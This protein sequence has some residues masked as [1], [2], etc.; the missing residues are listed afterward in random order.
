MASSV[1][2]LTALFVF[3]L[4]AGADVFGERIEIFEEGLQLKVGVRSVSNP[5]LRDCDTDGNCDGFDPDMA[6]DICEVL[7]ADCEFVLL[8]TLEDRLSFLEDDKV[9]FVMDSFS[10]T[11]ERKERI[12]FVNPFYYATGAALFTNRPLDLEDAWDDI[13]G[14]KVCI[15]KG[16]FVIEELR[17]KF[18]PDF[19]EFDTN[20]E[21]DEAFENDE[22]IAVVTDQVDISHGGAPV[23][24]IEFEQPFGI[25]IKKGNFQLELRIAGALVELMDDG[26]T[27]KL[28]RREAQ[29]LVKFGIEKLPE[30]ERVV[31]AISDFK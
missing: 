4:I 29:D 10:V 20:L 11:D 23:G 15:L 19:V 30:L 2:A 7:K 1:G 31:I 8:E 27:S 17:E 12:D 9:D 13:E 25:G 6:K 18:N 26:A 28:L 21:R 3:C 16:Y 22:C 14:R 24:K 5:P